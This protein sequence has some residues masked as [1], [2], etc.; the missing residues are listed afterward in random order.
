MKINKNLIINVLKR[1]KVI[2]FKV[3]EIFIWKHFIE[4]S[5]RKEN[6]FF[7]QIGA[8]D[9]IKEDPINKY[10]NRFNWQGILVEPQKDAF[11]ALK[12]NYRTKNRLIFENVAIT[13]E[14]GEI[15]FYKCSSSILSSVNPDL[16]FINRKT[17]GKKSWYL[18]KIKSSS[19]KKIKVNSITFTK[20]IEK[21]S[22]KKID[23]LVIDTEG[24]DYEIIKEINFSK[25]KPYMIRYEDLFL[26]RKEKRKCFEFLK[27][28]GYVVMDLGSDSFAI[29]K[30]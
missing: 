18:N 30:N 4:K 2:W 24:Y 20:L 1:P 19:T 11:L 25:I 10:I 21:H 16:W 14:V 6:F 3:K 15:D 29:L 26:T 23:L 9:G 17:K 7:I 5:G 22:V 12:D 8:N 13:K 27:K 28:K